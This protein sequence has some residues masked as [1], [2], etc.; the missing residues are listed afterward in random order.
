V[1]LVA[2]QREQDEVSIKSV[3][4]VLGVWIAAL[5][6]LQSFWDHVSLGAVKITA[7]VL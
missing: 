3:E 1:G 4:A 5:K 7:R 6:L 2:G